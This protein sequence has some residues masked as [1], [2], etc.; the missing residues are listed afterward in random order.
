MTILVLRTQKGAPLTFEEVDANFLALAE[1]IN[2]ILTGQSFTDNAIAANADIS[3]SKIAGTAVVTADPRLADERVPP[4]GSVNNAKVAVD[5][6]I[7]PEKIAGTAVVTND[8]RLSDERAPTDES[9]TD[10]K[11]A[12]NADISPSK[13]AG[14]AVVTSDARLSDER[15]P[16]DESVTD[17]KVASDAAIAG[18]KIQPDFGNQDVATTGALSAAGIRT[19]DGVVTVSTPAP[20][21]EDVTASLTAADLKGGL[22]VS[23]PAAGI[24]LTLPTGAVLGAGF[25]ATYEGMAFRWSVINTSSAETVT[26][27]ASSDHTLTG[28]PVVAAEAS[29][30]FLTRRGAVDTFV[31]YRIA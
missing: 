31:T 11:V 27:A 22:V 2:Q 4:D 1:S 29:A 15:V 10:A 13:I 16:T 26:L 20:A 12:A 24:T 19:I 3:P 14:T 18:T 23:L 17:A 21:Q 30:L 5:A 28:D 6:G 25:T 9:V 7:L 8:A